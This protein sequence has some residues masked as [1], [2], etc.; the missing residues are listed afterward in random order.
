MSNQAQRDSSDVTT[1]DITNN[2]NNNN[3][4]FEEKVFVK[5]ASMICPDGYYVKD[6]SCFGKF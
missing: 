6:E 5:Y 1:T 4:K 3:S 2:S